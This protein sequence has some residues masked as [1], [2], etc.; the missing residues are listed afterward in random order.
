[1]KIT[2]NEFSLTKS[3]YFKILLTNAFYNRWFVF[4]LFL[5]VSALGTPMTVV[6]IIS[7]FLV[8]LLLS[9]IYILYVVALNAVK[10]WLLKGNQLVFSPQ[11]C[12]IDHEFVAAY[13]VDGS[14]SKINFSYIKTVVRK[15]YCLF[16]YSRNQFIYFPLKALSNPTDV[17]ALRTL[18]QVKS[19]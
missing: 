1:M 14:L 3:G 9:S 15:D 5:L 18:I 6:G 19:G 11:R 10:A 4:I 16:Y 8:F 13:Y 2:T 12:E 7:H 17:Q